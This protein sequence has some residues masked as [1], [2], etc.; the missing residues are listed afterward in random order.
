MILIFTDPEKHMAKFQPPK[1]DMS[2]PI[3]IFTSPHRYMLIFY[4]KTE[5]IFTV[6]TIPEAAMG[7]CTVYPAW[8]YGF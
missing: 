2:I 3:K 7:F 8:G 1:N 6:G 5:I 4:Q